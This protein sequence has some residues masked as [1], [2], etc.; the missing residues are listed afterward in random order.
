MSKIGRS[1]I[2]SLS[3]G[4]DTWSL[5]KKD[6]FFKR[7]RMTL[8]TMDMFDKVFD[9][10]Y[11]IRAFFRN[12]A[13]LIEYA[14]FVWRHRNWDYGMV[15]TFQKKLYQ[16]LYKGCYEQGNHVFRKSEARKLKTVIG[17]LGRLE[18]DEYCDWQYDYLEKKYGDNE[19]IFTPI[20]D[21][22]GSTLT[23]SRDLRLSKEQ[24]AIYSKERQNIWALEEI[25]RKQDL[26]LF[27]KIVEKN[28]RKW[29]D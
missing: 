10:Y 1:L 18:A 12:V 27:H 6:G 2:K 5:F 23:F 24:K 7:V 9:G 22:T 15:F 3:Q 13:R 19:F 21:G 11:A 16:D 14:P 20:P 4:K 29:W 26:A 17:L 8:Y 28:H 25:Q